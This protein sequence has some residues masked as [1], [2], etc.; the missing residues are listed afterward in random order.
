MDYNSHKY[1]YASYWGIFAMA[2]DALD[3]F[4][5]SLV[6]GSYRDNKVWAHSFK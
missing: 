4:S 1:F 6:F 2:E 3:L 5:E